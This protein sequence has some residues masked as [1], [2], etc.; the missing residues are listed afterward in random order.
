MQPARTVVARP[1]PSGRAAQA[2]ARVAA[3][4]A[5]APS[6][7]QMQAA[8]ARAALDAAQIA[9]QAALEAQ[10]VARAALDDLEAATADP[11]SWEPE[12]SQIVVQELPAI[13]VQELPA[14]WSPEPSVSP[15][16]A[17]PPT[18]AATPVPA[19]PSVFYQVSE[20]PVSHVRWDSD[21]PM[22]APE[23]AAARAPRHAETLALPVEDGR[24]RPASAAEP[25]GG[26][27]IEPVE[28][29]VPIH[30]NLIEFPREL[31]ATRKV[32]PRLAEGPLA[33]A[34][35]E[36][37]LSIFE[38][39][40]GAVSTQP[41]APA[42]APAAA[43]QA[44]TGPEWSGIE[45]EAQSLEETLPDDPPDLLPA[46]EPASFGRRLLATVVDGALITGAFLGAAMTAMNYMDQLPPLRVLEV[47]AASA[48]AFVAL[49]YQLIFF[50]LGESTPG[51]K[52]AR[53]SLCTFDDQSP[54]RSQVRRRLA[55][56]LLSVVPVGLGVA[57][58][59]FD[60]GHLMWH[61]RLSRTYLRKC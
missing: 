27:A 33:A 31:I 29:V 58:A 57:W 49:L 38:V 25:W 56:L 44:W 61:D 45:L 36:M 46:L 16:Q 18:Q 55:A 4:Y 35:H 5:K 6:Y 28:A 22:H 50:T 41:E 26:E 12:E 48:F 20:P 3:R 19:A 7:S 21:F 53:V 14:E 9:T 59:I 2:A 11:V 51:M 43:A 15:T 60:D 42:A 8:E 40:P 34:A 17:V 37:Q 30:A 54:T 32:R 13:V 47:G 39:D 52:Y 10:G 1:G 23:P 24:T